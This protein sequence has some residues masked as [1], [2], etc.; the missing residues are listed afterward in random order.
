MNH[1]YRVGDAFIYTTGDTDFHFKVVEINLHRYDKYRCKFKDNSY[2]WHSQTMLEKSK[3][4]L[5]HNRN[6]ANK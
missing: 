1:E 4:I 6:G 5:I 2:G 3:R